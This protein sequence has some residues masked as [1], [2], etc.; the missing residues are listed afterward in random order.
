MRDH[1]EALD[2]LS[3]YMKGTVEHQNY[4]SLLDI[5]EVSKIHQKYSNP[6]L[7]DK[8]GNSF[9]GFYNEITW[10]YLSEDG[11]KSVTNLNK[12]WIIWAKFV[13]YR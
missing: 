4:D 8:N 5:A 9:K 7:T 11:R 12:A 10:M 13:K 6:H 3:R 1:R 2:N